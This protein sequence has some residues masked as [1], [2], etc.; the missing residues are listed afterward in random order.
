MTVDH[1]C[2]LHVDELALDA[3]QALGE[4]VPALL[5]DHGS[6]AAEACGSKLP[7]VG[8]RVEVTSRWRTL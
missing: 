4:M 2:R 8:L 1:R 5:A 6:L 3:D 7:A